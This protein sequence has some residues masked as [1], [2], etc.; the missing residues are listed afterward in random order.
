MNPFALGN[1][2]TEQDRKAWE[3]KLMGCV[4]VTNQ[5]SSLIDSTP[6][7]FTDAD[8]P[9]NVRILP[10][11]APMTKDLQPDRLNVFLDEHD[12]VIQVYYC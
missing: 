10:P 5:S 12:K 8:L 2:P 3:D 7:T 6:N 9:K 11:G 1:Q 4:Y